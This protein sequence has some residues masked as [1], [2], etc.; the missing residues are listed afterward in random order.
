MSYDW[1]G[2]IDN[3]FEN[4]KNCDDI[5]TQK[6]FDEFTLW[7]DPIDT[8]DGIKVHTTQLRSKF[9]NHLVSPDHKY[10]VFPQMRK[11]KELYPKKY[12]D[13]TPVGYLK[14]IE[15]KWGAKS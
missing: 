14:K 15:K 5:F 9:E 1:D 13:I 6:W 12:I 4:F 7:A 11:K 2:F 3:E 8:A 10:L